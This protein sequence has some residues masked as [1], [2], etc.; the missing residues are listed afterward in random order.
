M[1]IINFR[2]DLT[3]NSA[4]KE[5]LFVSADISVRSPGKVFMFLIQCYESGIK[6]I[7]FVFKPTSKLVGDAFIP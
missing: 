4:K 1:K 5:A 7:D 3:D 6:I 2:G